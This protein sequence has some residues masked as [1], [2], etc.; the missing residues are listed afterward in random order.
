MLGQGAV[1]Y[2]GSTA[3]ALGSWEWQ[4]PEDGSSQTCDYWFTSK[5]TS[6]EMTQGEAHQ[7]ALRKLYIDG[8]WAYPR[9]EMFEWTL[10]GNPNLS[11]G[12]VELSGLF[13]DGFESG[14]SSTWTAV[15]GD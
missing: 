8:L 6:G 5:V 7:W 10:H 15:V 9:Y 4:G 12:D 13:L 1:G 11:M 14:D 3:A 2:V